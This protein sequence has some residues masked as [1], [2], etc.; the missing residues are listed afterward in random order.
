M[1]RTSSGNCGVAMATRFCTST[2]AMSRFVPSLNVMVSVIVPS[3]AL[4]LFMYSMSSTPLTC[5]SMGVAT[6][7]ARVC[8][9]APG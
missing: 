4:W 8:G 1:L 5:S 9:F 6:V 3:L 2:C 7:S